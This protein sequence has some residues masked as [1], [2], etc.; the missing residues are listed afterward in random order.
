MIIP[1]ER[2]QKTMG[3]RELLFRTA[4]AVLAVAV[5]VTALPAQKAP[6]DEYKLIKAGRLIDT[7][8]GQVLA[9]QRILIKNGSVEKVG[10]DVAIPEGAELIDLSDSTVLPGF[11]DTHVHL[12]GQAGGLGGPD[13]AL[14]NS[15]VDA[16]VVSH[17]FAKRT[18]EAGFTTVRDLGSVAFV[19]ISLR[20]AINEGLIPGPRMQ[21]AT[22]YIGATG[23]HGD[24]IGFSP[25]LGSKMPEEMSGIA[26]GVDGVRQKVRY[27]I[28]YGATV[29]KFGASAGVL[30]G[31]QS[32]GAPQYSQAEMDAIVEEAHMHGVKVTA[33][34]HGTEAI[35]MAIKAGADSIEHGSMLDDEAITMMKERGVYLSSDIYN[36]DYI[37][38][39]YLKLGFP[40][41]T[42]DKENQIGDAQRESFRKAVKA[43]VKITY[44]TDAGVY[45]HGWNGRQ[46]A[47]MVEF[48][49]TPMQAIQA[50][51]VVSAESLGWNLRIGAIKPGAFADIVAVKGDPLK[52]ISVLEKVDFVMKAGKVYRQ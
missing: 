21:V 46:F 33:H 43:G 31:E 45:P 36:H 1:R 49:M 30:S 10:K 16:A 42:I 23:S 12:T 25:W 35:K 9:D 26:D 51:T 41:R 50:A 40:Q 52:D 4:S 2:I 5:C 32:V 24:Q 28:K 48:G 3:T 6:A 44:G 34:A 47:K 29:I 20:N 18:L 11:I 17:V 15:F 8:S 22:Y 13:R 7:E 19:V 37:V 14:R 39:E 27:L 38:S